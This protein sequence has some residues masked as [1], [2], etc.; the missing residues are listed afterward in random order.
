[1]NK[2]KRMEYLIKQL[3]MASD[4]YYGGREEVM[5]N[6]EWDA[7]FDELESIE[8]ETGYILDLPVQSDLGR[9]G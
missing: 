1:M 9:G 4:A 7:L 8:K 5:S 6:Y 3:N 2:T